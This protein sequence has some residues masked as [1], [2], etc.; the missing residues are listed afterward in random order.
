MGKRSEMIGTTVT[1][2]HKEQIKKA[3]ER[4]KHNRLTLSTW[5][6]LAIEEKLE[7]ELK[8]VGNNDIRKS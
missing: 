1:P 6:L 7:R 3:M 8:A 5:V 4:Y 2:E